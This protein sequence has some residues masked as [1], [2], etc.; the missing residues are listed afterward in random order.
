MP[1]SPAI[2][3]PKYLLD[4]GQML[5]EITPVILTYNEAANLERTLSHL[6]WAQD[7]VIV[8]SESTDQTAAIA[9]QFPQV[10]WFERPFDTIANQWR[11]AISETEI[12]SPW[13]LRLDADFIVP[14]S[15]VHELSQLQPPVDVDGY[16]VGFDYAIHGQKLR[17]SLYPNRPVL[18]R[19]DQARVHDRG[20][21]DAWEFLGK[22]NE[23]KGRII[24]DDRKPLGRWIASQTQYMALETDRLR[25]ADR[26]D[27][28]MA[29]QLRLVPLIMPILSFFYCLLG[30]GLI[31]D[32][33]A[34]LHYSMQRLIAETILS[35]MLLDESYR[36]K[37]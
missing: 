36:R 27:L 35:L 17:A 13:I 6:R 33:K 18:F 9:R 21:Q 26:R 15:F 16:R 37:E 8:D 31:L 25:N 12:K 32:G 5:S 2:S 20:H 1:D 30:K 19:K 22:I 34:G 24:H 3:N 23:F 28:G 10:R 11:F 14:E 4:E 29:D 7:I